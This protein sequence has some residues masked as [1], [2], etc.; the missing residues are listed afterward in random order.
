MSAEPKKWRRAWTWWIALLALLVLYPLS[1]GPAWWIT[2][3]RPEIL[4]LKAYRTVYAPIIWVCGFSKPLIDL[5]K[6]YGDFWD[7]PPGRR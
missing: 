3:H 4:P 5:V 7:P 1:I 2:V 6:R